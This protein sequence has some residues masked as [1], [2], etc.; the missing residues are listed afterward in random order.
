M[1]KSEREKKN[2]GPMAEPGQD[3]V[4]MGP[5][6]QLG[7]R[8]LIQ[9]RW[10]ML[11]QWFSRSYLQEISEHQEPDHQS[12]LRHLEGW[13]ATGVL[14]VGE[15]GILKAIWDLTGAC[16]AGASF[17]LER[18]PVRQEVIE[19][20]ERC[21]GNPYRL[22]CGNCLVA[23]AWRGE[24]LA[25]RCGKAGIMAAVI[26]QIRPGIA[27]EICHG[28]ETGYLEHPTE[29]ELCRILGRDLTACLAD[30]EKMTGRKTKEQI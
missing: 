7:T 8:A 19:I 9:A 23:V 28:E 12:I 17:S 10:D 2:Q 6:G 18:I 20:C 5:I 4:V 29:D 16:R 25:E 11:R 15:G 27:R 24:A 22:Y 21:G 1:I 26:G 14:E 30:L 13:G 3:L